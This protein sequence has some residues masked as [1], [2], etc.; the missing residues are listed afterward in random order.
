[1]G[2]HGAAE[3]KFIETLQANRIHESI[4][5]DGVLSEFVWRTPSVTQFFQKNPEQG[6]PCSELTELWVAYDDEALYVAAYLHDSQPDSIFARL[7]RRDDDDDNDMFGVALDTYHDHRTGYFFAVTAAGT[8]IDGT[9]YND[10]WSDESWDAVWESACQLQPD[11]W[12]VE[13]RIPYSQVRFEEQSV[14]TFGINAVREIARKK[15]EAYLVYR[16]RN[17]SRFVS[18]FPHLIGIENIRPPTRF[19]CLPYV[20][21]KADYRRYDGR[22]P[23]HDGS[24]YSPDLGVDVK[25]GLGTNLTLQATVNPDFGQVEVD[26]AVVNLSDVET[27][28]SEKR[29]FFTEGM[30]IFSFGYGGVNSYWNFNWQSPNIFYTRRIGRAPQRN[31]PE[32]DYCDIPSGTK[33]LGAAKITGKVFDRWNIGIIGALTRR[34]YGSFSYNGRQWTQ[35]IE[36]TALYSIARFQRDFNDGNQGIGTILTIAHRFLDDPA[37]Q[38][39]VNT[40]SA[41]VGIDGWTSLDREKVYM[42]SGW[43]AYS[44]I[45]GTPER[46]LAVQKSSAHYFQR[47]GRPYATVDSTATTLQG[48]AGRVVVN[49]Q[50]GNVVINAAFGWI[51]PGFE[52]SDLGFLSRTDILNYHIATGYRWSDPTQYYRSMRF[53]TCYFSTTTFGGVQLWKGIWAS[54]N[55]QFPNY[56]SLNLL[57]D[58]GFPFYDVYATRGGPPLR[59]SHGKEYGF[60]YT[61]D[62]RMDVYGGCSYYGY[63]GENGHTQSFELETTLRPSTRVTITLGPS[64]THSVQKPHWLLTYSD[65]MAT[66]TFGMRYLF[67]D[68]DYKEVAAEV[69]VNF[70]L[71]TTI[72]FQM[73]LQPFFSTGV[74]SSYRSL[75]RPN[76]NEFD[77]YG[78]GGS[79]FQPVSG[80]DGRIEY[81]ELDSDGSGPSPRISLSNPNFSSVSFRGNA[82]FRWEYRPGSTVYVVWTHSRFTADE[83]SMLQ[84][85]PMLH[86]LFNADP[87]SIVMVKVTYWFGV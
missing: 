67:A 38:L 45:T 34:E 51:S 10:D 18:R 82:V 60:S 32:Y 7:T 6:V 11:G 28:Y 30:S 68:L 8:Q 44:R 71:T 3:P 33:I 79:I 4:R 40:R 5:I 14:Y 46:I 53:L 87:H 65:A 13:F 16:P 63:I 43:T 55:Y 17:E 66:S 72:S 15:E 42:I 1:M 52:S 36:P 39:D 81:Y 48:S 35:E 24:K 31:I 56:H 69:R 20:L 64:Y 50:K 12:S 59:F 49:K 61:T 9:L 26:P 19:E 58:Y 80:L 37:L 22:N 76:S 86:R 21:E 41:V 2:S 25:I 83:S 78:E 85:Q 84:L 23:F 62:S 54:L 70:I 57:Y 47:P 29:P 75:R 27:Y 77:I 74:Y 73:F